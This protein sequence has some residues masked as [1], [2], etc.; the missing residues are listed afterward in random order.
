MDISDLVG[1]AGAMPGAAVSEPQAAATPNPLESTVASLQAEV[2]KTRSTLDD[3]VAKQAAAALTSEFN[4][5]KGSIADF[6][7]DAL[8]GEMQ[9]IYKEYVA[10]GASEEQA[11][12][13][14]DKVY[15]NPI[16]W[17]ALWSQVQMKREPAPPDEII[18]SSSNTTVDE[19]PANRAGLGKIL[20]REGNK[21]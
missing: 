3:M 16:G 4:N 19:L 5:F 17:K 6:D 8:F 9:S 1:D 20:N 13:L 10:D 18:P 11:Q 12:A 7:E 21:K 14:V 15:Q 2:A